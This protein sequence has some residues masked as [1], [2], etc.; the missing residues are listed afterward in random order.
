[1]EQLSAWDLPQACYVGALRLSR[2]ISQLLGHVFTPSRIVRHLSQELKK[3]YRISARFAHQDLI[4]MWTQRWVL[5]IVVAGRQEYGSVLYPSYANNQLPVTSI[6]IEA[7]HKPWRSALAK[8]G[9]I[10]SF[11]TTARLLPPLPN[12]PTLVKID[13]PKQQSNYDVILQRLR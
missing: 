5:A 12:G 4:T 1:M 3:A 9:L 10:A 8:I 7:I 6:L 2:G 13:M 11:G